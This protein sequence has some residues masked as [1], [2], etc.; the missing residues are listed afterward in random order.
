MLWKEYSLGFE[1]ESERAGLQEAGDLLDREVRQ[2]EEEVEALQKMVQLMTIE[3]QQYR[4]QLHLIFHH[5]KYIYELRSHGEF[6][7]RNRRVVWNTAARVRKADMVT[8]IF[9]I[10]QGVIL[11]CTL[12]LLL[13]YLVLET[14]KEAWR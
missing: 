3:G 12:F 13:F 2:A 8:K 1:V 4:S 5:S 14:L 7:K 9:T 11:G 6:G 10:T